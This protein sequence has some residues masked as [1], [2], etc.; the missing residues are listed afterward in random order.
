MLE[1]VTY[2][3]RVRGGGETRSNEEVRARFFP[4]AAFDER[5]VRRCCRRRPRSRLDALPVGQPRARA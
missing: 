4:C 2:F 1:L 3:S 5:E